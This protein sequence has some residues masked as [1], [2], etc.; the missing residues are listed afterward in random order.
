MDC[1]FYILIFHH[2]ENRKL[3]KCE[4]KTSNTALPLPLRSLRLC[5]KSKK[6]MLPTKNPSTNLRFWIFDVPAIF[7]DS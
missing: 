3:K 2:P 1:G 7:A 6:A 5:V 4:A